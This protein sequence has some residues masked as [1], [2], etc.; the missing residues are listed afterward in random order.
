MGR[1]EGSQ[2]EAGE[3]AE[4]KL[5]DAGLSPTVSQGALEAGGGQRRPGWRKREPEGEE[6][7]HF[8]FTIA[9]TII[10]APA[11]LM[12]HPGEVPS[13]AFLLPRDSL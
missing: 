9:G 12:V 11:E 6:E 2:G 4:K 8:Y 1:V 5:L 3:L 7:T 13:P 10:V